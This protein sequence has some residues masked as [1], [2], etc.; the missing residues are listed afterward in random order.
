VIDTSFFNRVEAAKFAQQHISGLN[1]E[2]W[3][4]ADVILMGPSRVGKVSIASFL[5][6]SG[7]KAATMECRPDTPLPVQ[8][9]DTSANKVLVLEMHPNVL[10]RRRKN[11]VEELRS[12]SAPILFEP[13]YCELATIQVETD[14]LNSLVK[15]HPEWMGPVDCTHRC[16][17]DTC[18][19]ILGK[20]R[21]HDTN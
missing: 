6:Q 3:A 2:D 8:L 15:R 11:R 16:L 4:Q 13:S 10:L 1:S 20:L 9:S 21:E 19:I 18:G 12:K 5:A 17:E 7:L 14:Y